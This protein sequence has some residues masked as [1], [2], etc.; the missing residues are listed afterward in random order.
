MDLYC[1]D[2]ELWCHFGLSVNAT[3]FLTLSQFSQTNQL[4]NQENNEQNNP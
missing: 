1:L 4:I 2:K 3:A